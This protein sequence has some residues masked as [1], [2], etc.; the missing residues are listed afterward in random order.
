LGR[1]VVGTPIIVTVCFR[2]LGKAATGE[3]DQR[4]DLLDDEPGRSWVVQRLDTEI[5]H[6]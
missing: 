3:W 1:A 2:A 6:Q 4:L 5:R